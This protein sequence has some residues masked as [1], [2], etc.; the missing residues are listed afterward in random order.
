MQIG[1]P[2]VM[3]MGEVRDKI[4]VKGRVIIMNEKNFETTIILNE[5]KTKECPYTRESIYNYLD[6][7][8]NEV[9][10]KRENSTFK[11]GTLAEVLGTFSA[12][13]KLE[14]F[15]KLVEEWILTEK[16]GDI[17]ITEENVLESKLLRKKYLDKYGM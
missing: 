4:L 1:L 3:K 9:G 11:S 15:M 7:L 6:A 8:F 12:L 5:E 2:I 17:I 13:F 14:W 10:M 16:E